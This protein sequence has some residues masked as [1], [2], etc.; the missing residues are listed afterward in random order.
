MAGAV[1]T[2]A[3]LPVAGD[4]AIDEARIARAQGLV[5]ESEP[6]HHT[7]PELLDHDVAG[8][9]KIAHAVARSLLLQV[10]GD[11][12]LAAIEHRERGADLAPLRRIAAHLFAAGTLDFD[13]FGAG[14]GE[15]QR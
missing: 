2:R 13:D 6:V 14:F 12:L 11:A 7:R 1:A 3:G 4:R 10:G 8:R 9:G 5:T 15:Q